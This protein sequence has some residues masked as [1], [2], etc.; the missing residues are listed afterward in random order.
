MAK[1]FDAGKKEIQECCLDCGATRSPGFW[2]RCP[3][4]GSKRWLPTDKMTP[5]QLAE[6]KEFYSDQQYLKERRENAERE[7]RLDLLS[8]P[9]SKAEHC[10]HPLTENGELDMTSPLNNPLIPG[11]KLPA[12]FAIEKPEEDSDEDEPD[13][14]DIDYTDPQNNP[15][16]PQDEG[17]K[18]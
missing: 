1:H 15:L 16:I 17:D 18:K 6:R 5:G 7:V 10:E 3:G 14:P 13:E 11:S 2:Q 12:D 9:A 4:C 8:E